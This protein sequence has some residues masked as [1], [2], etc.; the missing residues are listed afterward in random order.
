MIQYYPTSPNA[1][2][3]IVPLIHAANINVLELIAV[4]LALIRWNHLLIN[5]RV[6]CYC[7]N[8]QVCYNLCKDKTKNALSN[9]CL[10]EIFWICVANNMFISPAYIT[11][12]MNVDADYLSR[13][14]I[15]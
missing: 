5:C 3:V 2:E 12:A 7:N 13:F 10:G 9:E 11:S 8:L 1:Y 4:L 15:C 6:L 14:S